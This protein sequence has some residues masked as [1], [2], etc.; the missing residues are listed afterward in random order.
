MKQIEVA[1]GLLFRSGYLL[2]AKRKKGT[3]LSGYWEFPGGKRE[4]GETYQQCL[5]RELK[6]EIGLEVKVSERLHFTIHQYPGKLVYIEFFICEA[7][8]QNPHPLDCQEIKWVTKEELGAY[9]FPEADS[10]LIQIL[11]NMP[12]LWATSNA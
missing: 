3:H 7:P 4:H 8:D 10:K 5:H 1:A 12:N 6:E 11:K 9:S 2:I